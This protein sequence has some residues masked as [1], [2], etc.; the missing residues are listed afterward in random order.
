MKRLIALLALTLAVAAL[1][2]LAQSKGTARLGAHFA[3]DLQ[4]IPV[5]GNTPGVNGST[6]QTFVALL[7]PTA[8]SFPVEVTLYDGSGTKHTATITLAAGELKTYDN[9]LDA[10][11]HVTGGG[12][13]TLRAAE[14]IGGTHNNR[15]I[16]DAE[17]HTTGTRYGTT[18]P[19]LE[20]AGTS[21][22]SLAAGISVNST[23][24]TN[25]GCFNQSDV[26]NNIKATVYDASGTQ[27]LGSVNLN[28]AGNAWGQT[29]I[30]TIVSNGYIQFDPP[31][32]A[33]CYA[34]VVDN[35][36]NDG[37]FITAAEY[38]P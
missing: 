6:F 18:I 28:L 26:A 16:V 32:A 12:A 13:V 3:S 4:T 22:R 37:R 25:V 1:P 9:F 21:S 14:S 29:A 34:V 10:V 19:A 38:R 11:F 31:E 27:A 2:L 5:M 24:R 8:A 23:W 15:F 33:V 35:T 17:V 36:T 30:P 7:N 20:F